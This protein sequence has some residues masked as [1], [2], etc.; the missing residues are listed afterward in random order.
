MAAR[1]FVVSVPD[2]A[3]I[4]LTQH[5]EEL[6]QCFPRFYDR[7]RSR[8]LIRHPSSHNAHTAQYDGFIRRL[9]RGDVAEI[10]E[11]LRFFSVSRLDRAAPDS[12]YSLRPR[13]P[14]GDTHRDYGGI[15]VPD[16]PSLKNELPR[17]AVNLLMQARSRDATED[18]EPTPQLTKTARHRQ[19]ADEASSGGDTPSTR[20][21]RAAS[22]WA[23]TATS[24]SKSDQ[25]APPL[26]R[27]TSDGDVTVRRLGGGSTVDPGESAVIAT[28]AAEG[29]DSGGAPGLFRSGSEQLRARTADVAG[30]EDVA[31]TPANSGSGD[32]GESEAESSVEDGSVRWPGQAE[33]G[34]G[35]DNER[36]E[37]PN[38][39]EL[40][41]EAARRSRPV[42]L[43]IDLHGEVRAVLSDF[44]AHGETWTR[45]ARGEADESK[46]RHLLVFPSPAGRNEGAFC[47]C[48]GA[49]MG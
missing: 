45:D 1:L 7:V 25:P 8:S 32:K 23:G 3:E 35:A 43:R 47:G 2:A 27:S 20:P 14:E 29:V 4:D 13:W 38:A 41:L 46:R 37:E 15:I 44:G 34:V 22:T 17:A 16:V 31:P 40:A 39:A 30:Y 21:Q 11:G 28:A 49:G 48:G 36:G 12:A 19:A 42:V 18:S 26:A 24:R 5:T 9:V 10:E 6:R 33:E